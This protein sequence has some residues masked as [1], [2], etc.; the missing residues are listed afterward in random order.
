M[1]AAGVS[2][3]R[4]TD[5]GLERKQQLLDAAETL[6]A[7]RGYGPTR[8][9]DICDAAGVAKGLFYWYFD[10]KESL[11]AE[12]VR[13]VR[14]QLRRA[15]AAAM[16]DDADPVTRLRQGTDASVR[17][18]AERVRFFAL[19][20]VERNDQAVAAVLRESGDVYVQD[21]A[22]LVREAQQAG[23]VPEDH[24]PT[25]LAIGV[26]GAVSQFS[27]YHRAGRVKLS[28]DELA[29][30]VGQ[31]TVQALAAVPSPTTP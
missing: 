15:Q 6:F 1:T 14:Q 12:L 10:T 30:F 20:E 24:D 4:H 18:M 22:R 11:F 16:D 31:W 26:L 7:S 27:H 5:Q 23:L 19:L 17:F 13:S 29:E 9:A 8:I 2:G 25:L 3:R 21:A 28:I